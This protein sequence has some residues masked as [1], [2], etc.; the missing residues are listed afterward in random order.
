[1]ARVT[2]YMKNAK[3][4]DFETQV[5][6]PTFNAAGKITGAEYNKKDNGVSL[7]YVDWTEVIAVT[8]DTRKE[9]TE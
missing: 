2:L 6:K 7:M 5:F 9:D 4:I 1:M 8:R 3:E